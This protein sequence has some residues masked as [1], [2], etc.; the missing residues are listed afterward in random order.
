[1]ADQELTIETTDPKP[2]QPN[3]PFDAEALVAGVKGLADSAAQIAKAVGFTRTVAPAHAVSVHEHSRDGKDVGDVTLHFD[4]IEDARR[5][6]QVAMLLAT[7]KPDGVA[8]QFTNDAPNPH[9]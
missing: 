5:F 4:S 7:P 6:W 1:V 2:E 8:F 9:A 3:L